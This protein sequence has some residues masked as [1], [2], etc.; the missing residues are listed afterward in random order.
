MISTLW[1][2]ESRYNVNNVQTLSFCFISTRI[3]VKI[4][5]ISDG[6]I[7]SISARIRKRGLDI[8]ESTNITSKS[9]PSF[10]LVPTDGF[11]HSIYCSAAAE[12]LVVRLLTS[13]F[14][15]SAPVLAP[16]AT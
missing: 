6:D 13:A 14:T 3:H 8:A 4:A 12:D 16:S 11:K 2:V 10:P 15:F 1:S 7:G 5:L 9:S